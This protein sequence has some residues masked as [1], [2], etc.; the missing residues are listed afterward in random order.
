MSCVWGSTHLSFPC[1]ALVYACT[2]PTFTIAVSSQTLSVSHHHHPHWQEFGRCRCRQL[3]R[4]QL[5]FSRK[6]AGRSRPCVL[7]SLPPGTSSRGR[8]CFCLRACNHSIKLHRKL[9]LAHQNHLATV[10]AT[11]TKQPGPLD[12]V[13]RQWGFLGGLP[14]LFRR[15]LQQAAPSRKAS[16]RSTS[17][18]ASTPSN[19]SRA[20]AKP[21]SP[22]ACAA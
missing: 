6:E 2:P 20:A 15:W 22:L 17:S 10:V 3:G 21:P 13:L 16:P 7:L 14:P 19:A 4:S 8:P 12:A 9:H 1:S 18:T 5:S 11:I